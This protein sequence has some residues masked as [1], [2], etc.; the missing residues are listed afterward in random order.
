[1]F[2]DDKVFESDVGVG[3]EMEFELRV[4]VFSEWEARIRRLVENRNVVRKRNV[5]LF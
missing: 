1:M 5:E 3:M 2:L 4:E